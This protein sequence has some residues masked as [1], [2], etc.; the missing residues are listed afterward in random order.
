MNTPATPVATAG[1]RRF[2]ITVVCFALA[3]TLC[4]IGY[5]RFISCRPP[6]LRVESF[7]PADGTNAGCRPTICWQ[8]N[9][10]VVKPGGQRAASLLLSGVGRKLDVEQSPHPAVP[11]GR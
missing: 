3:N 2:W 5:H 9:M 4:W 11:A 8:F 1:S 7:A 6:L 10:D